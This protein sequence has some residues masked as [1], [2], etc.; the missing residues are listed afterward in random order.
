M[1]IIIHSSTGNIFLLNLSLV[2]PSIGLVDGVSL[3]VSII[4]NWLNLWGSRSNIVDIFLHGSAVDISFLS[5]NVEFA[6]EVIWDCRSSSIWK[7]FNH[8]NGADPVVL[9]GVDASFINSLLFSLS[10]GSPSWLDTQVAV[11]D[12]TWIDPSG[13]LRKSFNDVET[14]GEAVNV[15]RQAWL[16]DVSTLSEGLGVRLWSTS[17]GVVGSGCLDSGKRLDHILSGSP[18]L[19]LPINAILSNVFV[20]LAVV[21]V[22]LMLTLV[23]VERSGVGSILW[24]G[25]LTSWNLVDWRSVFTGEAMD[26]FFHLS[27]SNVVLMVTVVLLV[28]SLM[29]GSIM[30]ARVAAISIVWSVSPLPLIEWWKV[31]SN[32]SMDFLLHASFGYITGL[33]ALTVV[34]PGMCLMERGLMCAGVATVWYMSLI[35]SHIF[36]NRRGIFF[37]KAMNFLLNALFT[38]IPVVFLV[39][40]LPLVVRLVE[41]CILRA[42][43]TAIWNVCGSTSHILSNW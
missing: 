26:L 25:V 9:P 16:G 10:E 21:V 6:I 12:S 23:L 37:D 43:V 14:G 17:V 33:V 2:Q 30:S 42:W 13:S 34:L 24:V 27:L 38:D 40:M 31:F 29:E 18:S 39:M 3:I 20:V 35:A 1:N 7:S 28:S 36:S 5:I 19:D 22:L 15:V 11:I 32:E 8:W 4:W 41:R